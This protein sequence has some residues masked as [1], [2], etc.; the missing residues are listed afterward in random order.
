MKELREGFTTGSCA[1]AAAL[2]CCLWQRD[3]KCPD[4]VG[5]RPKNMFAECLTGPD[6]SALNDAI[7]AAETLY[8]GIKDTSSYATPLLWCLFISEIITVKRS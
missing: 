4:V 2:A 5:S 6:K 1:A 3:G 7:T 8:D